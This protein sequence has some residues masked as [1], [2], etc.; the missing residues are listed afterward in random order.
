MIP[1]DQAKQNRFEHATREELVAYLSEIGEEAHHRAKPETLRKLLLDK[2]GI[3][4]VYT[5]ALE[6]RPAAAPVRKAG[7]HVVPSYN[8]T[9]QGKWGGRRHRIKLPRPDGTKN[10]RA[11]GFS[12]NG[13]ATY[14][15]PY[16][17]VVS[18]P[19]PILSLLRTNKR[20]RAISINTQLHDGSTEITT[21][22]EFDD[23]A[24][25]Y[26]GPD[27]ETAQLAGSLSEWYQAKGPSWFNERPLRDLQL[28][29]Q[30]CEVPVNRRENGAAKSQEDL[31]ADLKLFFFGY[32]DA[33]EAE[34]A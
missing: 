21:G 18:I 32:A 31:C 25:S 28:I 3:A 22:W 24:F 33:V 15:I 7:E 29:A 4:D 8:L 14:W 12:F 23:L 16:D 30:K 11:E 17:E 6:G 9:A 19:E 13:K 27:P 5:Q 26:L 2:L 34:A 1:L 10:A 20:R